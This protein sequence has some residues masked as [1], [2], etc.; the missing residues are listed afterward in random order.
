MINARYDS[1]K[2]SLTNIK[3]TQ[4]ELKKRHEEHIIIKSLCDTAKGN[5]N[6]K[7][8]IS[9]ETY[10]QMA[11]FERIINK[12]NIRRQHMTEGQYEFIRKKESGGLKQ[13]GLDLDVIDH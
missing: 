13:T 2:K 4:L 1:N 6:G 8:K 5:V 9:L 10:V 7:D 12:A 11:Y 3:E